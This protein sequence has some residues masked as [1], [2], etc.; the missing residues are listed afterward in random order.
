MLP[1]I[2]T[3]ISDSV[4]DLLHYWNEEY[5]NCYPLT[6]RII[7]EK[8]IDSVHIVKDCSYSLYQGAD[9]IG[10]VV[11]KI[12]QGEASEYTLYLYL[13]FLFVRKEYRNRGFGS[14]FLK[15]AVLALSDYQKKSI[16]IGGDF[17]NIFS[18]VF[19]RDNQETHRFFQNRAQK[20]YRC[21][22][23]ICHHI[24]KPDHFSDGF[25]IVSGEAEKAEVLA[26]IR[27]YFSYRWYYDVKEASPEEFVSARENDEIIGFARIC[28]PDCKK[29]S[30]SILQYPLYRK[31]GGIGPLGIKPEKRGQGLGTELVKYGVKTLF[32][33][34]CTEVIVDWTGL[35]EFYRK[36]GFEAISDEYIAYEIESKR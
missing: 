34:N 20:L 17:D 22:N 21:F 28:N 18:G 4:A 31:L 11:M 9:Y 13:S 14:A 36:C 7:Q 25:R 10:S 32:D 27:K 3:Q 26:F 6:E 8:L 5:K 15:D 29:L 19:V 33:R 24:P 23:M 12:Y 35:T 30:N 2:R 16:R 1:L